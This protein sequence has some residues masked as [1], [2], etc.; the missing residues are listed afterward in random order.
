M[1]EGDSLLLCEV[2]FSGGEVVVVFKV[3]GDVS[4]TKVDDLLGDDGVGLSGFA[5]L[6]GAD[7]EAGFFEIVKGGCCDFSVVAD[8]DGYFF[9]VVGGPVSCL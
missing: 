7:D 4:A 2:G 6:G 5:G 8:A 9:G 3:D 1:E